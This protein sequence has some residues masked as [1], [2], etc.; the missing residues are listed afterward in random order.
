MV[1]RRDS[2]VSWRKNKSGVRSRGQGSVNGA[3]GSTHQ[4]CPLGSCEWR[5]QKATEPGERER[6]G[7]CEQPEL[8]GD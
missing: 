1:F 3:D 6:E 4:L 2:R 7:D 5:E 8:A